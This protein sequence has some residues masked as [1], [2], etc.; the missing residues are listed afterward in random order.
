MKPNTLSIGRSIF[1][2]GALLIAAG[3]SSC[4]GGGTTGG[5]GS[6]SGGIT[7]TGGAG[8]GGQ[9]GVSA[10]G[11]N[12]NAG[13]S[14][15]AGGIAGATAGSGG[16]ATG[17]GTA[18]AS[19]SGGAAG[20]AGGN[21]ASSGGAGGGGGQSGL[22]GQ[23]A[24]GQTGAGGST[25]TCTGPAP[26]G[27]TFTT[28][29]T[30]VTFTV[31]SGKMKVQVCAEDII[32]VAYTSTASIPTTTSLSV[33]NTWATPTSF[34]VTEAAGTL[35]ITTARMK[36]KVNESTGI[37]SYTDLSDNAIVA[38]SSKSTAATTVQGTSTFKIVT[39][40]TSASD[41]ALFG[42][43]QHPDGNSNYKG[44]SVHLQNSNGQINIPLLVS[45][46]G[47]G[48]FWD[49]YSVSDFSSTSSSY[50]YT[51]AAGPMV[52]YYFFYGPSID[53]VIAGYRTTTGPQPLLPKW[54]YGLFQ[55]KDHYS[56]QKEVLAVKDGYRNANIPVD[57]IVQD[58]DYWN[59]TFTWGSDL[60]NTTNYPDPLTMV[61]TLHQANIHGMISIWPEFANKVDGGPNCSGPPTDPT[62]QDNYTALD[63]IGALYGS[64][65]CHH[66]YDVFNADARKLVYQGQYDKLIGKYGWDAIWADNDEPQGYPDGFPGGGDISA[67]DTKLGKGALYIN[68]YAL[69]HTR[70]LWEGWRS[71]GPANKRLFVLSRSAFAGTQ[72]FGAVEWSGDINCDWGVLVQQIPAGLN[73]AVSGMPYW[74]TDIGGYFGAG[75]YTGNDSASE[76]FTRW[77]EFGAFCP[78]FQIHGQGAR[79]LY[80]TSQWSATTRANLLAVDTLRYRLMPYIYSLGWMVTNQGYTIMRPLVFDFQTDSNVFN[81]KDQFMYGPAILVNPVTSAG[82]TSRSVYLP[83]G[84]WYDFWTGSTATGGTK[85]TADAPLSKIPLYVKAGSIVPMGPNIQYATQSID[86]LEIRIYKGA[87]GS[88]TLYEDEGDTYNYETGQYSQITF[89]WDDTAKKLSV[90]AR[91]G[92]Y[93]GMPA[94]RTFNVVWVGASHG[95]GAD[96][97]AT[98]DQV[99]KYD[100]TAT[101]VSAP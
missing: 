39:A 75:T 28:D 74:T 51:S 57:C 52:D 76:L 62:D 77:F 50:S 55:S 99:V 8:T 73:Y 46:K 101:S 67:V 32:R 69:E 88:F 64:S 54:A 12:S 81:I 66:F 25:V 34:C 45:N 48:I 94:S 71:V 17:G 20:G 4:S 1:F 37:V 63:K 53:Q 59:P 41:E 85:V 93:T 11:G 58:W 14:N 95:T 30:G 60:M 27:T 26:T 100:G 96:V 84:T 91:A 79:E 3:L 35:T 16:R 44:K 23:G 13:G 49:N 78:T 47:Y 56:T 65:S 33:S 98:A 86:P 29:A 80:N 24:G 61:N 89:T 92:T 43:G 15:S 19:G 21:S 87:N 6:G 7:G 68:A 2:A 90:G 40:F 18:G 9:G 36:V 82:A 38:E 22:G 72:R 97:T 5:G 83:A 42:L 70:T 31:G 10:S